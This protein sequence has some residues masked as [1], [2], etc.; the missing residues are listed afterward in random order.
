[1]PGMVA[2][3]FNPSTH[4]GRQISVSSRPAWPTKQVQA[5]RATQEKPCLQKPKNQN[6]NNNS[7]SM[8]C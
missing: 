4:R 1:M 7:K 3:A 2:R 8:F 5:A 6:N